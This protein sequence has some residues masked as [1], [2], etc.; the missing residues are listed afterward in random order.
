MTPASA[1]TR[2]RVGDHEVVG[3]EGEGLPVER[4]ERLAGA[5]AA[6]DDGVAADL[7]EVEGVQRL[8]RLEH[9]EVGE[10][11]EQVDAPQPHG[12]E[13]A[14]ERGRRRAVAHALDDEAD[15]APA[16]RGVLDRDGQR[17]GAAAASDAS[18]LR[19]RGRAQGRAR[20]ADELAREADVAPQ[21]G[22]VRDRGVVHLE[23]GVARG[24]AAR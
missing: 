8:P 20:I 21:V 19:R 7:A 22:A 11:D 23:H 10:V 17:G 1:R 16:G 5:G 9:H 12:L 3:V 24:R 13:A 6:H 4:L 18:A 2:S 14:D 15:V